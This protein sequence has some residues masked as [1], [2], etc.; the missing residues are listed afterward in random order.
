MTDLENL[1]GLLRAWVAARDAKRYS[2]ARYFETLLQEHV[3]KLPSWALPPLVDPAAEVERELACGAKLTLRNED[4]HLV[5]VVRD[6]ETTLAPVLEDV[7]ATRLRSDLARVMAAA[8]A[9][10]AA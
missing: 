5:I 1:L 10:E 6:E 2:H 4:G 9:G 7:E 3:R 8:K